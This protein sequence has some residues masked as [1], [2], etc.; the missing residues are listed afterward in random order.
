MFTRAGRPSGMA[1]YGYEAVLEQ[2]LKWL[3]SVQ[4]YD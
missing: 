4:A 2:G 3:L 1:G